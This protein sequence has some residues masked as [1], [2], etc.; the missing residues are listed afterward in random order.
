M[1][2]GVEHWGKGRS[3]RQVAAGR[4]GPDR[5]GGRFCGSGKY[6]MGGKKKVGLITRGGGTSQ[7]RNESREKV[8][9]VFT[10]ESRKKVGTGGKR[11]KIRRVEG[12]CFVHWGQQFVTTGGKKET[13][14]VRRKKRGK[15]NRLPEKRPVRVQ[16]GKR[17]PPT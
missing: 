17:H 16:S 15:G 7:S 5:Q 14:N 11:K 12:S 2:N 13:I 6:P 4:V 1:F 8:G 10:G 3:L 9:S